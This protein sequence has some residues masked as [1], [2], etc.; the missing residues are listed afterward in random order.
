L[1]PILSRHSQ[2]LSAL[3]KEQA[4]MEE[5]SDISGQVFMLFNAAFT[6]HVAVAY[7]VEMLKTFWW[8]WSI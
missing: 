3:K 7:P 8:F 2:L 6:V 5:D 4:K 1:E